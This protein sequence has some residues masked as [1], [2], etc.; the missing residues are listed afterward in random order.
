ML[1]AKIIPVVF[2][3]LTR[4][5]VSL[6]KPLLVESKNHSMIMKFPKTLEEALISQIHIN[7]KIRQRIQITEL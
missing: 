2:G 1:I 7:Y 6:Q 5:V 3:K 4:L